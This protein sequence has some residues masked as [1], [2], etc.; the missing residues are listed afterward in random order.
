MD[1]VAR[2]AAP[3]CNKDHNYG[4][5]SVESKLSRTEPYLAA[6]PYSPSQQLPPPP[7]PP[8]LPPLPLFTTSNLTR[9]CKCL[10]RIF[11]LSG[12]S[13]WYEISSA[14]SLL[15]AVR[16]FSRLVRCRCDCRS[17]PFALFKTSPKYFQVRSACYHTFV[18]FRVGATHQGVSFF[19]K[20]LL[21]MFAVSCF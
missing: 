20:N 18:C 6:L 5:G 11:Y 14:T 8:L 9:K 21:W 2:E 1:V 16:L 3:T 17:Y 10:L 4:R 13:L 7:L 19:G 12:G 15:F